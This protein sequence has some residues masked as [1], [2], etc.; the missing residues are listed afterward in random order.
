M[1]VIQVR[2]EMLC[3]PQSFSGSTELLISPSPQ[4]CRSPRHKTCII[5]FS[6]RSDSVFRARAHAEQRI[7]LVVSTGGPGKM[8]P[9]SKDR[10][11]AVL[12]QITSKSPVLRSI[13]TEFHSLLHRMI[14]LWSEKNRKKVF[15]SHLTWASSDSSSTF[16]WR[17][18]TSMRFSHWCTQP[19]GDALQ[20]T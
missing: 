8:E 9:Q 4:S 18:R 6:T 1:H 19:Q 5:P 3:S 16:W 13:T 2:P 14:Q 17:K 7:P 12:D 15:H 10:I 11:Q 20:N